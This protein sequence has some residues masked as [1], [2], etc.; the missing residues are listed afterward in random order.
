MMSFFCSCLRNVST[1]L[2]DGP[3]AIVMDFN[4]NFLIVD[5]DFQDRLNTESPAYFGED[6][7][8][9]I[10]LLDGQKNEFDPYEYHNSVRSINEEKETLIQPPYRWFAGNASSDPLYIDQGTLGYFF[11]RHPLNGLSA[12]NGNF[13]YFYIHY[14]DGSEDV[15]KVREFVLSGENGKVHT[16]DQIWINDELAFERGVWGVKDFYYNPKYFSWLAPV[17]DDDGRQIGE[18]PKFGFNLALTK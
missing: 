8:Q 2:D 17:L 15:I 18:R 1:I 14:P 9:G 5:E 12:D 4:I 6:Y 13:A 11:I 10:K 16:F 3:S 7:V